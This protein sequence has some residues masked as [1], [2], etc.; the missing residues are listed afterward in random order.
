MKI[1]NAEIIKA[2]ERDLIDSITADL[3]WGAIEDIFLKEHNLDI[4]EDIEY[5]RGDIIAYDNQVAYKL[6]FAV[7]VNLTVLI[8]R[9]G[10]YLA[11]KISERKDGNEHAS[12]PEISGEQN[13]TLPAE[14]NVLETNES[15]AKL[16][17]EAK[18]DY[19]EQKV[20]TFDKGEFDKG[21]KEDKYI[22]AIK[23]LVSSDHSEESEN[24]SVP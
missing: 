23:E 9:D 11:V 21:E 16:I 18:G 24:M 17:Q 4:D 20:V 13:K 5:K 8:N 2:G 22:E 3:D 10:D 6:E 15:P 1:T 12:L 19:L 7:K 14:N